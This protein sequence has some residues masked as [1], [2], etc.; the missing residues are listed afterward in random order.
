MTTENAPW[1]SFGFQFCHTRASWPWAC[2]HHPSDTPYSHWEVTQQYLH[3]LPPR[4]RWGN[5]KDGLKICNCMTLNMFLEWQTASWPW[6]IFK[7]VWRCQTQKQWQYHHHHPRWGNATSCLNEHQIVSL[8]DELKVQQRDWTVKLQ[9]TIRLQVTTEEST[10]HFS[11]SCLESLTKEFLIYLGFYVVKGTHFSGGLV[12]HAT[13]GTFIWPTKHG[14]LRT[15][16][17]MCKIVK[18][19]DSS[20]YRQNMA[21]SQGRGR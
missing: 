20:K 18:K 8:N 3:Y 2:P 19:V 15:K 12:L 17:T 16:G 10:Q 1:L 4:E 6:I 9:T 13:D 5:Q 7:G 11:G 21:E 14:L